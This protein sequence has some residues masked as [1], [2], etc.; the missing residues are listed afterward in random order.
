MGSVMV[1]Q[2]IIKGTDREFYGSW[3]P[4]GRVLKKIR[5]GLDKQPQL[6]SCWTKCA[7]IFNSD[8][9]FLLDEGDVDF[10]KSTTQG[11]DKSYLVEVQLESKKKIQAEFGL[12]EDSVFVSF[13]DIEGQSQKTKKECGCE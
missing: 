11:G 5:T 8:I 3:L 10:S 12:T 13:I 4:E 1:Y 9:D 7:G 6:L 2:L